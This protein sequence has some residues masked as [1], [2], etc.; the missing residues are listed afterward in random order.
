M[1]RAAASVPA[2]IAEGNARCSRPA[3]VNHLNIALGSIAELRTL[4][5]LSSRLQFLSTTEV[6]ALSAEVD[7][8]ARLLFGLRRS[9]QRPQSP[10]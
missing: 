8:V 5:E 9:L 2:N 3:Y 10:A 6:D 4:I 1:R 7:D